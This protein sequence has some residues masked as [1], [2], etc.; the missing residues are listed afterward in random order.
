M[1]WELE[2]VSSALCEALLHQMLVVD[3]PV[4]NTLR[5]VSSCLIASVHIIWQ[6]M[7]MV[8]ILFLFIRAQRDGVW[9]L[10]LYAF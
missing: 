1:L 7:G 4:D 10:Y 6:Y 2:V 8:S 3:S 5:K 9:D